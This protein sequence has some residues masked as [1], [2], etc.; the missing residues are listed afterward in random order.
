[1]DEITYFD[2]IMGFLKSTNPNA[3]GVYLFTVGRPTWPDTEGALASVEN[4]T[5]QTVP[6]AWLGPQAPVANRAY[7]LHPCGSRY[8]SSTYTKTVVKVVKG[9]FLFT[10]NGCTNKRNPG[11]TV[12]LYDGPDSTYP[13]LS[14]T[15]TD[16]GGL[17]TVPYYEVKKH[18]YVV[19]KKSTN[20][21]VDK[22][23]TFQPGLNGGD[24][25]IALTLTPAAGYTCGFGR[26]EPCP[27]TVYLHTSIGTYSLTESAPGSGTFWSANRAYATLPGKNW[28][29][30]NG[31]CVS[32]PLV[33]GPI[34]WNPGSGGCLLYWQGCGLWFSD[35]IGNFKGNITDFSI[36]SNPPSS[37]LF[38]NV[39]GPT[40]SMN[41]TGPLL[42]T[43]IMPATS[44]ID[45][46]RIVTVDEN[47]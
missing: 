16:S 12:T 39:L 44:L 7:L 1:M 21:F 8:V 30:V 43:Y 46:N 27:T 26:L 10:V 24:I 18:F 5:T 23:G 14:E 2:R 34:R 3:T 15:L 40:Q 38:P 32:A 19:S 35:P 31:V 33:T 11:V 29:A 9:H 36:F 25:P 17:A 42:G 37:G 20:R 47:P 28:D 6:V 45:A 41:D 13:I 22:S 4:D